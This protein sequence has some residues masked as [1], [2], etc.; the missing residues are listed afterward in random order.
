MEVNQYLSM[1]IDESKDHL[2]AMNDNLLALENAPDDMT[3]VQNIFRS[4]HTLKGMSATM[5]F[6][7]LAHLTHEMENV[8]DL[9]RNQK[10]TMDDFI[11]DVLFKGLDSL[12]AMVYDIIEGGSGKADVSALVA[13]LQSIVSGDYKSQAGQQTGNVPAKQEESNSRQLDEFQV[14]ILKQSMEQ[15]VHAYSIEVT[16]RED[17]VLKAA[18]A[19]MVFEALEHNGEV[20]QSSPSVQDIENEK[21]DRSFAVYYVTGLD[22]EALTALVGNVSEIEGVHAL[23]LTPESLD[24]QQQSQKQQADAKPAQEAA[25][26]KPAGGGKARQAQGNQAAKVANRTIRVDIERLDVLMNLFSELLIDRVR[27]E[28]LAEEIR[29]NELTETVEHMAR[30]SSDLQNIVL[31]LRMV[32][33]ESVFNR[34]PR[35]IRD[36]SKSLEKKVELEIAGADTELDRTVIDEI[37]DPLVHLL[38]NSVD[39][40]VEMPSERTSNGK[41]ETGT[42][43]LRAYHSGNHVFIE[44]EDDGK[45]IDREKVLKTAIKNNVVTAEQANTMEDTE[46]YQLLFASGF[47]TADKIS[48]ISGR[49]VGLDVVKSKIEQLGG[50]VFV[51][52][53]L[54][55]GTKF[56]IQLPLTLSI[57]SA[58]LIRVG[59]EKYAIPLSSIVETMAIDPGKIRHVHGNPMINYREG[60][61]PL[62]S[63]KQVFECPASDEA[64]SEEL[65]LIIVSKGEKIISLEVEEFIGQQE[66]VLKSIGKY[67]PNLFGI[68][69]A[70]IL[71]DGQ[72]SLIIDPNA[73]FK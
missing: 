32:P 45:G 57:I 12:E 29:K 26:D 70:T 37:G 4:A 51:E 68:S 9:L 54:G 64:E 15:G 10:L 50:H 56:S 71:G 16:I 7:D 24:E 39:H 38:R 27:L 43:H 73:L 67:L 2:Q 11:F 30:V 52:S 18:R 34:F 17:C 47:S 1:F 36:I 46:V 55:A 66:I 31:K 21:F 40:G 23:L 20:I 3:I 33:V 25:D 65:N 14:S 19:Y 60:V 28:S 62:V 6:E 63:L 42:I 58:M 59:N 41:P 53:K 22:Q 69:G 61:I 72:V 44:I 35:M 48:D 8:L 13:S 49:G 5:G